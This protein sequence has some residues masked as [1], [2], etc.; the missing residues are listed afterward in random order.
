VKFENVLV[1]GGTG[2]LGRYVVAELR[3]R[4]Q[5]SVLDR[6]TGSSA[7][8]DHPVDVLDLPALNAAMRGHDAVIHLA[9]I[10]SSV[11]AP[12]EVVFDT[13]VRG[14]WAALHAAREAGVRRVVITSSQSA[15]GIDY[16]N[17]ALAPLYLPIDEA[18]PLRPTQPYG[19]SKQLNE[20][21]GQSFGSRG[22]MEVITI[23]PPWVMFADAIRRVLSE[24]SGSI[25]PPLPGRAREP[26]GL[27][28]SYIAPTDLAR[29]YRQALEAD[30]PVGGVFIVSA[31]DTYEPEPT[32]R[33]LERVYGTLPPVR[34]PD[35]YA[36]NP[37][38][39]V[40]DL[41]RAREVLGWS[42]SVLWPE[43]ARS[44]EPSR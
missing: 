23:R 35:L 43:L 34:K 39:S 5:V 12:P 6:D 36:D 31:A 1:T 27:L 16:T 13:N 15:L 24:R 22:G 26:L 4:C 37:H 2:R 28:R 11:P 8:I 33:H 3:G 18:H 25:P 41:A 44:E 21:I 30:G 29:A 19:L 42:P 38:A 40:Y 10:D 14:T 32:L 7:P 20:L 9:A 17:P